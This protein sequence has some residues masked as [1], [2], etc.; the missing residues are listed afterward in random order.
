[1]TGRASVSVP[2]R[3]GRASAAKGGD[4]DLGIEDLQRTYETYAPNYLKTRGPLSFVLGWRNE[5]SPHGR[6]WYLDPDA[7][8]NLSRW[9]DVL[10]SVEMGQ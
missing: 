7:I 1:M 10:A 6:S 9:S 2:G 8:D 4:E 5:R 3:T